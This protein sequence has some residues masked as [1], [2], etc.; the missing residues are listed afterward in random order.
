MLSEASKAC[1]EMIKCGCQ[2][3]ALEI[4]N[5]NDM[6][7]TCWCGGDCVPIADA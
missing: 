6:I 3:V 1:Y 2:K 4:V 5:V 7:L